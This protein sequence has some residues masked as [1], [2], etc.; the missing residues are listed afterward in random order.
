MRIVTDDYDIELDPNDRT[1]REAALVL[2]GVSLAPA[3]VRGP[4]VWIPAHAEIVDHL[5]ERIV[6][7][8]TGRTLGR[9]EDFI[10][11]DPDLIRKFAAAGWCRVDYGH[12]A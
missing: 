5:C 6:V 8:R 10:V 7:D 9:V 2:A 4:D 3:H 12:A 11:D 1:A